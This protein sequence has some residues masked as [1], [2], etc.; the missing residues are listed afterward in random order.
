VL[1]APVGAAMSG[2]AVVA[3]AAALVMVPALLLIVVVGVD[4]PPC[5]SGAP[6]PSVAPTAPPAGNAS[7]VAAAAPLGAV[8]APMRSGTF[9]VTSPFGARR[10]SVHQ[11]QDMAA[12]VGTDI[13]AATDGVVV[14]SGPASGFGQWIVLDGLVGGRPVSTVY[15]HMFPEGVLV[16]TGARV[17][18]GQV[19]A[20]VGNAGVSTGPH[21]HFEVWASGRLQG[22]RVLDPAAWLAG[23]GEPSGAA[24]PTPG[25]CAGFGSPGGVLAA[26]AVPAE[27]EPWVRRAGTVCPGISSSLIAAQLKAESGFRS[28]ASTPVSATGAR[29]PAQFMP[30]TWAVWG[31]DGDGNGTVDVNSVADAVMSQ[32]ALMCADYASVANAIGL[33]TVSGDPVDLTLAAYNAGFGAVLA[34]RGMPTGGDYSAQTQPYVARIRGFERAFA[35]PGAAGRFVPTAGTPVGEQ[36]VTAARQWVGTPYAWGGGGTAG[37][38][39]GGFDGPGLVSAAVF[40][41]T[42]GRVSL[43]RTAAAQAAAGAEV[44]IAQVAAGD[45]VFAGGAAGPTQV[46]IALGSGRMIAATPGV[47][48]AESTLIPGM[49]ARRVS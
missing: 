30:A 9:Q 10:G 1:D 40:A 36:V 42:T 32:A 14:A 21:L 31:R 35:S 37:P 47:G 24:L 25:D 46:G 23:G 6:A 49:T 43:P 48:V 34:A 11:G 4:S 27:F 20:K 45:L 8:V 39:G 22:G 12:P 18:A 17:S 33:G 13:Y 3:A 16:R 7:L 41:A 2:K 29:G 38:S 15:G 26:A 5:G 28:G 19:I 44:P